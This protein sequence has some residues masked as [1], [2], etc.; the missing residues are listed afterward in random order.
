[1]LVGE[2]EPISRTQSGSSEASVRDN[3]P[4]PLER[5]VSR[6]L[7][8]SG[9]SPCPGTGEEPRKSF[10]KPLV[11]D[12]ISNSRR[13]VLEHS[14]LLYRVPYRGPVYFLTASVTG[15]FCVLP[16]SLSRSISTL[17]FR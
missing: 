15:V 4:S 16:A 10:M 6:L 12:A 3:S 2:V 17:P 1:M 5:R 9:C 7:P 14:N 13:P 8:G 11:T